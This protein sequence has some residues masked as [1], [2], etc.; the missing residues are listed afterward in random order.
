MAKTI[1]GP[2][3][4]SS[5][6]QP[7]HIYTHTQRHSHTYMHTYMHIRKSGFVSFVKQR[8]RVGIGAGKQFPI[9]TV[10]KQLKSRCGK[11][12][13]ADQGKSDSNKILLRN[14]NVLCPA[15]QLKARH[16]EFVFRCPAVS[17]ELS[18]N[19]SRELSK[20]VGCPVNWSW[21]RS[22]SSVT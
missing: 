21:P 19:G 13:C 2:P 22:S 1:L 5:S 16:S 9:F 14:K 10:Y 20:C 18:C 15:I 11:L 6:S 12:C 8:R 3:L 7:A 17:K 4:M